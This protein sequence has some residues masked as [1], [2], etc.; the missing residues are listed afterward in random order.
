MHNTLQRIILKHWKQVL[1]IV[2]V[3]GL[4]YLPKATRFTFFRDDWYYAVDGFFGGPQIFHQMFWIDRPYRGYLFEF[5]FRW[6]GPAPLAFQLLFWGLRV[7]S[8]ILYYGFLN[9]LWQG[10]RKLNFW[11][12]LFFLLYPG[13]LWWVSAIEYQPNILCQCLQI[14]SLITTLLFVQSRKNVIRLFFLFVSIISGWASYLL[15]DFAIG[16]ELF[17]FVIL[18]LGIKHS[19]LNTKPGKLLLI[20]LKHYLPLFTIPAGF[21]AWRL[22]HFENFRPETDISLQL[23]SLISNPL[24]TGFLWLKRTVK[25]IFTVTVTGWVKPF[26]DYFFSLNLNEILTGSLISLAALVLIWALIEK[27]DSNHGKPDESAANQWR[28]EAIVGGLIGLLGGVLPVILM[29]REISIQKYSHYLLPVLIASVPLVPAAISFLWSARSQK[30]VFMIFMTILLLSNYSYSVAVVREEEAIAKFWQQVVIRV[31]SFQKGSTLLV[32]LPR[33]YHDDNWDA[34]WAPVNFLYYPPSDL[35]TTQGTIQY[36]I[37]GLDQNMDTSKRILTGIHQETGYRTHAFQE[38]Y[39]QLLVISQPSVDSCVHIQDSR[40]PRLSVWDSDQI[41]LFAKESRIENILLDRPYIN[42]DNKIFGDIDGNSWCNIYQRA[43]LALQMNDWDEIS[44]LKAE[45]DSKNLKPVDQIEWLPFLQSAAYL[46]N[47]EQLKE[48]SSYIQEP[49]VVAQ[50][51]ETFK[52]M[53]E[54]GLLSTHFS[55]NESKGMFSSVN[56]GNE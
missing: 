48:I 47:V 16:L 35:V 26:N 24:V 31:P 28:K 43:E 46:G 2:I 27:K 23:G 12:A 1:L 52:A 20:T 49:F 55:W 34:L 21:F 6:L 11:I 18:Y 42:Y 54:E 41:L 10:N 50:V 53:Q 8:G 29:N 9:L 25:S 3:S 32:Q 17:R 30:K 22:F 14:I 38:N 15:V 19:D 44:S 4:A 5:L 7:L 36:L 51:G 56:A 45:A 33:S 39:D 37:A 40:W 13:F